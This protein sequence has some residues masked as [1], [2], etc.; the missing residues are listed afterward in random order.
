MKDTE[1]GE[2]PMYHVTWIE[3]FVS[4]CWK[5]Y[6]PNRDDQLRRRRSAINR[7][8]I[9]VLW[10]SRVKEEWNWPPTFVYSQGKEWVEPYVYIPYTPS[11]HTQGQLYTPLYIGVLWY[12]YSP[13][14]FVLQN[15]QSKLFAQSITPTLC[16]GFISFQTCATL[17]TRVWSSA[18]RREP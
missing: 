7:Q 15:L 1:A 14:L 17:T 16:R 8:C 6:W 18:I 2:N 4:C 12:K 11:W 13:E 9:L 3:L 5:Y 10:E